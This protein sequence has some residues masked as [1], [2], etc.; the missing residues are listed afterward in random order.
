MRPLLHA[1][2]VTLTASLGTLLVADVT[3][4]QAWQKVANSGDAMP[5]S[6]VNFNSFNP[7]SVNS[8][9]VVVFRARSQGGGQPIRGI[10]MRDMELWLGP[11][12]RIADLSMEVPWPNNTATP[13]TSEELATFREFPAFPRIGIDSDA[14][15]TR[16]QSS[17]VWTY[18][19]PNGSEGVVG[20]SGIYATVE[21]DL[22]TGASQLGAV[23]DAEASN[24]AFPQFAV[25]GMPEGTRFDQFPGAPTITDDHV[26]VFKG[27]YTDPNTRRS[28][29]GVYFRDLVADGGRAPVHLIADTNTVIPGQTERLGGYVYP[30]GS[31]L[32]RS[33]VEPVEG[34]WPWAARFGSTAPPSAAGNHAVFLGLDNEANPTLGGIYLA[35]LR[36]FSA[37]RTLVAIGDPVPGED[38]VFSRLGEA[39]SFDGRFVA[40][41]GAWGD[42]T[43]TRTLECPQDGNETLLEY[44]QRIHPDGFEVQVPLEQGIFVY[45][46]GTNRL[47][48]VAKTG[49]EFDD[50]LYWTFSGRPPGMEG[51][52]GE[53]SELARWRSS[54]FVSVSGTVQD[55]YQVAFKAMSSGVD[56]IYLR[57]GDET[58][59]LVD[60][61]DTTMPGG[62]AD[63][64]APAGSMVQTLGMERDSLRKGWLALTA[65]MLDN[66][67]GAGWAGVYLR[68]VNYLPP[69]SGMWPKTDLDADRDA[70]VVVREGT[71]VRAW[72]MEAERIVSDVLL[73]EPVPLAW[74]LVDVA[75]LDGDHDGDLI[76]RNTATGD[77]AVHIIQD[78]QVEYAT[79][80]AP[81]VALSWTLKCACDFNGDGRADL[82]WANPQSGQ[83]A[84]WFMDGTAI[85]DGAYLPTLEH[86]QNWEIAGVQDFD[87]DHMADIVWRN[88]VTNA[89]YYWKMAGAGVEQAGLLLDDIGPGWRVAACGDL[90]A[91]GR[92]DLFWRNVDD[93]RLAFWV[94][95]GLLVELPDYGP[96]VVLDNWKVVGAADND[97]DCISEILWQNIVTGAI[98]SWHV[99][100]VD[101]E[102]VKILECS[103]LGCDLWTDR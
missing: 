10:Y 12:F 90:N 97:G 91:D 45:D 48:T 56:G 74:V 61:I 7:P 44:C 55:G 76:W 79:T 1:C 35:E 95:G 25:P 15:A 37:L 30:E 75:D 32:D 101:L 8:K 67:T 103:G 84:L 26:I 2:A 88:T 3:P 24:W 87:G 99:E 47:D 4:S 86:P 39:L 33:D 70:D 52:E 16:A 77:V 92:S 38:A 6:A 98:A 73:V 81:H 94:M 65:G 80:I 64:G 59:P 13:P 9:G 18:T 68:H 57:H 93:G 5:D 40:F 102:N 83:L 54:T 62:V 17:P 53:V 82:L 96:F 46:L 34:P 69:D 14:I 27:N 22:V 28:A 60:V 41:W 58:A 11:V 23:W 71:T 66:D 63:A 43:A 89:H 42:R 85:A 100:D 21:Q 20:T 36:P 49:L 72:I 31:W 78:A 50:F 29:T 51:G 19:N